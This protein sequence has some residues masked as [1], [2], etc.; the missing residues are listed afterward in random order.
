MSMPPE[1]RQAGSPALPTKA[2]CALIVIDMQNAYCHPDGF[3]ARHADDKL[4]CARVVDP[5][6]RV[7]GAARRNGVPVI[8]AV[9]VSLS[10][11][12][13]T[14]SFHNTKRKGAGLM[15]LDGWDA[16]I[17]EELRPAPGELV[18]PKLAYS[19]FYGT[20][21]DAALQRLEIKQLVVVGVTT[22]IC[23]ESTVRDAAQRGMDVYVGHDASAEWDPVRHERAIEQ[24]GYAFA[25]IVTVQQLAD[26]WA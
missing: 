21:L 9:K 20:A 2:Q 6:A 26:S 5:C 14:M 15:L 16:A 10:D 19:A 22:S 3:F 8:H 13:A 4:I 1:V 18:L 17:V 23:V 11:N 24:M 12:V 25:R 7:V